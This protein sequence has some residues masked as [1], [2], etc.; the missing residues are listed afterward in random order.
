SV[1]WPATSKPQCPAASSPFSLDSS[2]A[3]PAFPG[4]F[5][6]GSNSYNQY[7]VG[8]QVANLHQT[9]EQI[10]EQQ[11]QWQH[12][13]Q[14]Q[15]EQHLCQQFAQHHLECLHPQAK[16]QLQML[17]FEEQKKYWQKTIAPHRLEIA[18]AAQKAVQQQMAQAA[19]QA[20]LGTTGSVMNVAA[21][22][23][24]QQQQQLQ[25]NQLLL[26]QYALYH[27][28]QQ[29]QRQLI[30]PVHSYSQIQQQV[31]ADVSIPLTTSTSVAVVSAAQS[32]V[33]G[34]PA[35]GSLAVPAA[36]S[37]PSGASVSAAAVISG[38][39]YCSLCNSE[40]HRPE[41]CDRRLNRGFLEG[42][43]L[44]VRYDNQISDGLRDMAIAVIEKY[45]GKLGW[46]DNGGGH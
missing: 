26:Q 33:G 27:H 31:Q 36:S 21:L 4:A 24:V 28:Q 44:M 32:P 45:L 2:P 18:A 15:H 17:S 9:G 14:Q 11:R 19:A 1:A 42:R 5:T 10:A 29:Q 46:A 20:T 41:E 30:H 6:Y 25:Q 37:L 13:Q 12:E 35:A 22:A 39:Q 7:Q 43:R 40:A 23:T 16:H 8:L 38:T 34:T 3:S